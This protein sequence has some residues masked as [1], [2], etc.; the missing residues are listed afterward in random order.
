MHWLTALRT[1]LGWRQEELA[2][3]LGIE[4]TLL[5]HIERRQRELPTA[6]LLRASKLQ[7]LLDSLPD[8]LPL[9]DAAAKTVATLAAQSATLRGELKKVQAQQ[10]KKAERALAGMEA[11]YTA[12]QRNCGLLHAIAKE[13]LAE[14]S[15]YL[16]KLLS[17]K[18]QEALER[19]KQNSPAH[20]YRLRAKIA[21]LRAMLEL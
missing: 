18:E 6:A 15:P 14:E 11:A 10:V 19:L 8:E 9:P 5:S 21:G 17:L 20:Q 4:R 12:A 13:V 16:Q 2:L 3:Y 7:H 1:R